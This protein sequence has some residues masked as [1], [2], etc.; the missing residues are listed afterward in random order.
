M[1]PLDFMSS[2]FTEGIV[3][4]G[5]NSLEAESIDCEETIKHENKQETQEI[6]ESN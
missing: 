2:E 1:N 4:S 5:G 6:E 3:E